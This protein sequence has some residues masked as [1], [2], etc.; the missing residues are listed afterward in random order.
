METIYINTND[1]A[2]LIRKA[3]K[4]AFKKDFPNTKF[5]VRSKKYAGGSSIDIQWTD[6]PNY[7]S[8]DKIA[9]QFAGAT[10]DGMIDLKEYTTHVNGKGELVHYGPDY[11]FT[12]REHSDVAWNLTK[13]YVF[14]KFQVVDGK[15]NEVDE[16]F[17]GPIWSLTLGKRGMFFESKVRE[18]LKTM[19]LDKA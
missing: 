7:E 18:I 13:Q 14:R 11:V 8:V 17:S 2:K 15:G 4:D 12:H 1:T 19:D 9:Q 16:S 3:L 10:F 6:G 5:S